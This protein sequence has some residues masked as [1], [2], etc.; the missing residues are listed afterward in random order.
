M[1]FHKEVHDACLASGRC[2]SKPHLLVDQFPNGTVTPA[3]VARI[4]LDV[5]DDAAL[6]LDCNIDE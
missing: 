4:P 3:P 6:L 2:E 1:D 5:G